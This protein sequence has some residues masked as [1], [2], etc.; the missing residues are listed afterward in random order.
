MAQKFSIVFFS[1][2]FDVYNLFVK[3]RNGKEKIWNSR[4]S[5]DL[6][7]LTRVHTRKQ[8]NTHMLAHSA[9]QHQNVHIENH[10]IYTSVCNVTLKKEEEEVVV[11]NDV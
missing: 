4:K 6:G 5:N 7:T 10:I 1:L 8:T 9:N 2:Q 11:A 3:K